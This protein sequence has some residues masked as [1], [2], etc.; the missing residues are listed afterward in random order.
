MKCLDILAWSTMTGISAAKKLNKQ[1]IGPEEILEAL[2]L[3]H[4]LKLAFNCQELY[5]H[6]MV[7]THAC[8]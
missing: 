8:H 7:C 3:A 4:V 1:F 5:S 6:E 2:N